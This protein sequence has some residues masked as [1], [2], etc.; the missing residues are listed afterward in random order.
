MIGPNTQQLDVR[1]LKVYNSLQQLLPNLTYSQ[2]TDLLAS[3]DFDLTVP[4]RADATAT[5]S[6]V[7]NIGA[8][9]VDNT[10]SNRSRSISFVNNNIPVFAG[11]T[12][13]F[14]SANGGNITTS[15]GGSTPLTTLLPTYYAIVLISIDQL[16]NLYT[17]VGNANPSPSSA[18]VPVAP[19]NQL[20]FAYVLVHNTEGLIDNVVQAAITQLIGTPLGNTANLVGVAEEVALTNGTTSQVITFPTALPGAN[21]VVN[22][23]MVNTVDAY[24][25]FQP[26]LITNKLATGF[27]ATWTNPLDTANYFLDYIVP[28]VQSQLGEVAIGTGVNFLNVTLAIP[29]A[30][31]AYVLTVQLV[32]IVDGLPQFQ[33]VTITAKTAT[34][35]QVQWNQITDSANYRLAYNAAV[36]Q[37]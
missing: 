22:A 20:P 14:P 19:V 3:I 26:L 21:Y 7:V 4:L 11:G 18:V 9:V 31:I 25:E 10:V 35:F 23:S 16:G 37:N 2:F 13:T 12:I 17:T 28:A 34:S 32:N 1:Q 15:T 5:P 30:S 24:P 6:L 27:T 8:Q 36:F 29:M 33:P